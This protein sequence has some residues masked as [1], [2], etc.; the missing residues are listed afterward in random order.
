M[1]EPEGGTTRLANRD[2]VIGFYR[3]YLGRDPEDEG[4]IIGRVGRPYDQ[5]RNEIANSE[6]A[7]NRL[8]PV[9]PVGPQGPDDPKKGKDGKFGTDDV[10]AQVESDILKQALDALAGVGKIKDEI[11]AEVQRKAEETVPGISKVVQ[12]IQ[13]QISGFASGLIPSTLSL[14]GSA[15]GGMETLL[16][17]FLSSAADIGDI[18]D[19]FEFLFKKNQGNIFSFVGELGEKIFTEGIQSA[20][21]GM[22]QEGLPAL[23][24][25]LSI[26]EGDDTLSPELRS[27][28]GEMKSANAPFWLIPLA[29]LLGGVVSQLG[30]TQFLPQL[31]GFELRQKFDNPIEPVSPEVLASLVARGIIGQDEGEQVAKLS[32][33]NGLQFSYLRDVNQQAPSAME[34]I[35]AK[36]R[37]AISDETYRLLIAETALTNGGVEVIN[38]LAQ[39]IPPPTDLITM[40]V[41]GAFSDEETQRFQTDE[42][43]PQELREWAEKQGLSE[44]WA[45]RYWRS[46]WTLPSPNQV[47]EMQHRGVIDDDTADIYLRAADYSVF[48]REKL[49]AIAFNPL[50]RV[51]TR[52]LFQ[53]DVISYDQMVQ[54][55]REQ[56]Y[57]TEKAT[58]LADWTVK[59][60]QRN[61]KEELKD[62]TDTLRS[63]ITSGV[64]AGTLSESLADEYLIAFGYTREQVDDFLSLARFLR[65]ERIASRTLELVGDLYVK[66]RATEAEIRSELEQRGFSQE[67]SS[68]RIEEWSIERAL[69]APTEAAEKERDLTKAEIIDSYKEGVSTRDETV[70]DLATMKYDEREIERLIALA[71]SDL[72]KTKEKEEI[73]IIKNLVLRGRLGETDATT[74]LD[75]LHLRPT[76]RDSL[77]S[78]WMRQI[79]GATFDIP[80]STLQAWLERGIRTPEETLDVLRKRGVSERD[81]SDLVGLWD[82]KYQEKRERERI[83]A[84]NAAKKAATA[85]KK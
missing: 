34:T 76:Q 25:I 23:K 6:E 65:G 58:W 61:K 50:T 77:V 54:S 59:D 84:E 75:A 52:R 74:R 14:V 24:P 22:E 73:E 82:A 36:M 39:V 79:E 4:A 80:L 21:H 40:A 78:S 49:K 19:L 43:F 41:K 46:H 32:G 45:R 17:T 63:T 66:G 18:G 27:I 1:A 55:Y 5:V 69:R 68:A 13:K 28:I 62:V 57:N 3:T 8:V 16:A 26:L 70:R 30:T 51:D 44:Y 37:G 20:F 48:W 11:L 60:L 81:A 67:E 33:V 9:G 10:K 47:F 42:Q 56:G 71:D 7:L 15:L 53:S 85:A 72:A 64:V 38:A 12:D 35:M 29:M 83:A 2:D 31:R